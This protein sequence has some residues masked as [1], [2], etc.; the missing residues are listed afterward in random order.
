M[1]PYLPLLLLLLLF[2]SAEDTT[3]PP[4]PPTETAGR[5]EQWLQF[6]DGSVDVCTAGDQWSFD[7][8][9]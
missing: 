6:S 9:E 8:R 4:P 5:C 1:K 3:P 2:A 7:I